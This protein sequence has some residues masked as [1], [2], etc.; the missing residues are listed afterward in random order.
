[1]K[2]KKKERTMSPQEF[3]D[4]SYK[5]RLHYH[6]KAARDCRFIQYRFVDGLTYREIAEKEGLSTAG[7]YTYAQG[8]L[9][10][11]GGRRNRV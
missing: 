3:T 4:I 6:R 1:M 9:Q 5:I 10:R 7:A 8:V 11:F 2:G